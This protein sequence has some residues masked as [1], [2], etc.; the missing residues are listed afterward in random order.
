MH[1]ITHPSKEQVR[2]YMHQRGLAN[3]PPPT[4]AEI[5]RQLSWSCTEQPCDA[6]ARREPDCPSFGMPGSQSLYLSEKIGHLAAL[7]ALEWLMSAADPNRW[8]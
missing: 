1:H 7:L 6:A 4:P 2:A 5:R 3:R 8:R